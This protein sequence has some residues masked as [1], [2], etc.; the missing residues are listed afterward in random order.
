MSN[1][2]QINTLP[3]LVFYIRDYNVEYYYNVHFISI[4]VV[5]SHQRLERCLRK[6]DMK[7][8]R[9]WE[10]KYFFLWLVHIADME[11]GI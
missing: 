3:K 10:T 11:Y 6:C 5:H 2:V 7:F 4:R 8:G 1:I 9:M